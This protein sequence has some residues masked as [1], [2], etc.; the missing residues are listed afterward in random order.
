MRLIFRPDSLRLGRWG[1]CIRNG[2]ELFKI[3]ADFSAQIVTFRL[4]GGM[5]PPHPPPKSATGTTQY[6]FTSPKHFKARGHSHCWTHIADITLSQCTRKPFFF[7]ASVW[8]FV[9]A[10]NW[11][12]LLLK[13][14]FVVNVEIVLLLACLF[15]CWAG[16]Y[17]SPWLQQLDAW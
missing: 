8:V 6:I 14:C 4:V 12:C 13:V 15:V 2:A 9:P 5:H 10:R 7:L 16:C 11:F 3:R 17:K 1:G